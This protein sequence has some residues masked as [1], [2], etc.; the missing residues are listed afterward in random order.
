MKRAAIALAFSLVTVAWSAPRAQAQSIERIFSAANEAYFRGD[1]K[2]AVEQYERLVDAGVHDPDV[3]FNLATAHA[4]LGQLGRAVFYFERE[5]WLE[6]GDEAAEQ[7]LAQAR[8][9]LGRRRAERD[10]QAM[11]Q[12]RPPLVE[13][14]V[15]PLSADL[16]AGW[17]LAFDVLLFGLLLLRRQAKREA[18]RLGLTI[19]VPL[20]GLLLL[21][22]AAGLL[23]KTEAG[24][25]GRAA[26]V[27]R[28]GAELREGPDEHAQVRAAAHEGQAARLLR[29]EG[30]FARV[31]LEAGERGWM[32]KQDLGIIR[33]D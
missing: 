14:L 29:R 11:L 7:E 9:V 8:A 12:A 15:R 10:G 3:Y 25:D 4:R 6:P 30:N 20:V 32:Q 33:P 5:L 1:L 26:V 22:S 13:A 21:A 17:L 23:V 24:K 19:S 18:V 16:L 27:L 31:Q 2:R 28:D